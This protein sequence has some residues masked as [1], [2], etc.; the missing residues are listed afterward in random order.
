[1]KWLPKE[2][3][4]PFIIVVV[5]TVAVLALIYY[6]LM[7]SQHAKL[8]K[9]AASRQTAENKLQDMVRTIKKSA[10]AS[11]DL[12]TLM[13]ELSSAE[14]DMA[15]GDLYAW[16]FGAMRSIKQQH[17]V[18]IPET[19]HPVEGD[20]D[21][22]PAFPYKQISF[23]VTGKAFYHDLGKFIADFENEFPHARMVNL[24]ISPVGGESEK[25][26]FSV[27]II[28]LVKSNAS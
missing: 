7:N 2:R 24:E 5:I 27:D 14:S 22:L 28:V 25:L 26:S 3:Q 17:K 21:L 15:T 18:E 12:N 6:V 11:S 1:M 16:T 13:A 20:V 23:N 9:I 10:Q 4:N 8:S 19:G